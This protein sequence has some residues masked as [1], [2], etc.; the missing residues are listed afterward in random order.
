M[1][2]DTRALPT[3]PLVNELPAAQAAIEIIVDGGRSLGFGHAGRCLALWEALDA[4]V[5][6]A[7]C[8][9]LVDEFVRG[10]GA[11]VGSAPDAPLVIVDRA[12]GTS[13]DEIEAWRSRGRRV[14]LIDD[15]G[16]GRAVADVVIDPPTAAEWTPSG[17]DRLAG[18]EHVLLRGEIR[19][20][21]PQAQGDDVLLSFGGSDP[22]GLT[23]VV[24]AE[25]DSAGVSAVAVLG[26]AY[27][28]APP[29]RAK[30]V[31]SGKDWPS[32]LASAGLLVTGYGH[33]V[34]EAAYL[35]IPTIAAVWRDE[36][37]VH[38]EAFCRNGTARF[39]DLTGRDGVPKLVAE[40]RDLVDDPDA[41]ARL[42][43][44]GREL[45]DGRGAAR[46]A[47]ALEEMCNGPRR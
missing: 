31:V 32:E 28:G 14:C 29:D 10:H 15:L 22:A 33:S 17:G 3:F 34:L 37:R 18:F 16:A 30:R 4:C 13:V 44:R 26:P 9:P 24:A 41:R 1:A 19:D 38:A 12:R 5:S 11:P 27:H 6:F 7:P 42:A 45:V 20:A 43:A 8:D 25:L 40:V 2:I 21:I 35:G 46:V 47:A 36:H 23:P 39:V